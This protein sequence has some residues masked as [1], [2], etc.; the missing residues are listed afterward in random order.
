MNS[1]HNRQFELSKTLDEIESNETNYDVRYILVLKAMY[2]AASVGYVTGIRPDGTSDNTL[3]WV[4]FIILP[5]IGEISWHNPSP[6][7][8]F[9]GYDTKE[10]YS[11]CHRYKLSL[12]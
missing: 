11:R 2:L 6:I 12:H 4:S 7:S 5:E 10:K 8:H 9:D 1:V 3:W